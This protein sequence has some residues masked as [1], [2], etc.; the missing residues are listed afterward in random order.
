M[1]NRYT[2]SVYKAHFNAVVLQKVRI[3]AQEVNRPLS[4]QGS[5]FNAGQLY[6]GFLMDKVTLRE[7]FT[8]YFGFVCQYHSTSSA[9]SLNL[10][11]TLFKVRSLER[12]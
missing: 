8:D 4:L 9:C 10:P 2:R 5:E 6:M 1:P 12:R 11:P 7:G 3:V